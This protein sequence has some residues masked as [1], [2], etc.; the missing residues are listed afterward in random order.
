MCIKARSVQFISIYLSAL[1]L[2]VFK[3]DARH[4]YAGSTGRM[5]SP[6]RAQPSLCQ[7]TSYVPSLLRKVARL[8][9]NF[10]LPSLHLRH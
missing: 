6:V 3:A 9:Y 5:I 8:I 1:K 7:P 2:G 10:F 4:L